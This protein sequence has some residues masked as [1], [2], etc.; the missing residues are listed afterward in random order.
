MKKIVPLTVSVILFAFALSM[1]ILH[2]QTRACDNSNLPAEV[3]GQLQSSYPTF[4]MVTAGDMDLDERQEW[5]THARKACPGYVYGT[6]GPSVSG[7]AISLIRKNGATRADQTLVFLR[8][9]G[10]RY[11]A[12][13]LSPS[14]QVQGH[15]LVVST[16]SHGKYH[17]VK[18]GSSL[19]IDWPVI[20][21]EAMDAG[22]E[23]YYY[24]SGAWHSV[25][26]S[27]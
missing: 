20:L 24:A 2:G 9:E 13:V 10:N 19:R 8:H 17:P 12:H 14:A 3:R 7:Y 1:G 6:F 4:H 22:I 18:G 26:L 16:G 23:G 5:Q 21:Y 25:L 15:V 27:K 11:S